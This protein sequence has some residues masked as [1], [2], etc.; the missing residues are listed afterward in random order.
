MLTAGSDRPVV[1]TRGDFVLN[2]KG[3]GG[4][5][6]KLFLRNA[7]VNPNVPYVLVSEGVL[8]EEGFSV[9]KRGGA[10]I[11][12]VHHPSGELFFVVRREPNRL[13]GIQ[14]DYCLFTVPKGGYDAPTTFDARRW[15]A[16][17]LDCSHDV[18]MASAKAYNVK[19]ANPLKLDINNCAS[20]AV[21]KS[22]RRDVQHESSRNSEEELLP[23]EEWSFDTMEFQ[24]RCFNGEHYSLTCVD[25]VSHERVVWGMGKK[26]ELVRHM[27][28]TINW[29]ETMTGNRCKYVRVDGEAYAYAEVQLLWE[30]KGFEFKR[31]EP[32]SSVQN[33]FAERSNGVLAQRARTLLF[34]SRQPRSMAMFALRAAT[35][36]T[37]LLVRPGEDKSPAHKFYGRKSPI[38]HLVV[39]GCLAVYHV[40]NKSKSGGTMGVRGRAG[41]MVGYSS[42]GSQYLIYDNET[43]Q[44]VTTVHV[45][46]FQDT[47]GWGI[48]Q[49]ELEDVVSG[50]RVPSAAAQVKTSEASDSER[51]FVLERDDDTDSED[52]AP[53]VVD[54][55][56]DGVSHSGAV[57][58]LRLA[59]FSTMVH[60]HSTPR[61]EASPPPGGQRTAV[62]CSLVIVWMRSTF[63]A[64]YLTGGQCL[65]MVRGRNMRFH[66]PSLS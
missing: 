1:D 65:T 12:E 20:C 57:A 54:L 38:F 9:V 13:Y 27:R 8:Q 10:E 17:T 52:P 58:A 21:G 48:Q 44:V 63:W 35:Y 40:K 31:S 14:A 3:T 53:A 7:A 33:P 37:N 42:D 66:P 24:T 62:L 5:W 45:R 4:T 59:H 49:S 16:I 18:A 36:I 28:R 64:A 6:R 34:R 39:Y 26:N 50:H 11:C 41:T 25:T 2:V 19:I 30:E 43:R 61:W 15:H 46:F 56:D 51:L 60:H 32:N 29:S 23:G 47:P 55:T 22:K